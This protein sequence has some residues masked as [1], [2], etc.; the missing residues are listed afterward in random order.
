MLVVVKQNIYFL[1]LAYL[2]F[3]KFFWCK[4]NKNKCH[5][6]FE[7][8]MRFAKEIRKKKMKEYAEKKWTCNNGKKSKITLK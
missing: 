5:A 2:Y 6:I 4:N 1:E 7:K 8:L 3:N